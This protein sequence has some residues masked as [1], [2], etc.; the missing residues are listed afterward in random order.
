MEK[1]AIAHLREDYRLASLDIQDVDINPLKQF[2][3]W[4]SEAL[5]AQILEPNAMTLATVTAEGRPA[6]RIV[7]LKEL[8]TEGFVFYTNYNS[9]KGQELAHNPFAALCFNWLD[10]QRQVRI[11][12]TVKKVP[13]SV[14]EAYFVSRPKGSQVGAWASPQSNVIENRAVLEEKFKELDEKYADSDTVP[15]PEHWGGYIV[16]PTVIEFWQGRSSRLHDRIR[17]TRSENNDWK[18]ERLAP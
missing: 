9:H 5:N 3:K 16:V 13:P 15:Y 18:I 7:L 14:S 11:E 1:L 8:D 6:A 4:F 17:Y 2:N 10:L 12:G